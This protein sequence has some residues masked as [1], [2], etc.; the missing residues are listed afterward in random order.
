MLN[1][2]INLLFRV[3]NSRL[4]LQFSI[5]V[6]FLC[7]KSQSIGHRVRFN[8]RFTFQSREFRDSHTIYSCSNYGYGLHGATW[9]GIHFVIPKMISVTSTQQNYAEDIILHR[10]FS[11]GFRIR[12]SLVISLFLV[13]LSFSIFFLSVQCLVALLLQD[14]EQI[15]SI[16]QCLPCWKKPNKDNNGLAF[17]PLCLHVKCGT[18]HT[19]KSDTMFA[20][21]HVYVIVL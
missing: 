14:D 6:K 11:T 10:R 2:K 1:I 8:I 17:I 19:R 7:R 13:S 20:R 5:I 21:V 16:V 18:T 3:Q 15:L 4:M 12:L 9:F